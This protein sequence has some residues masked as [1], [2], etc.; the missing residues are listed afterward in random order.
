MSVT[1]ENKSQSRRN[2]AKPHFD[3]SHEAPIAQQHHTEHI[4]HGRFRDDPYAWL[5]AD[6]WREILNDPSSLPEAIAHLVKD[7]NDYCAKVVAPLAELR[8]ILVEELRARIKEDDADVP[9]TDGDYEYYG[10]FREGAEHSLYCRRPR[11]GGPETILLDGES[12]AKNKDF[13]D[14]GEVSHAPDHLQLAWSVDETGSELFSIRTRAISD[15]VDRDDVVR[16]TDGAIVWRADSQG[17]YYVHI[18]GNHRS[19]QIRRHMLGDDPKHDSIILEEADSAWFISLSESR[20]LR[21]AIVSLHGHDACE[22]WLIDLRGE[23]AKPQLVAKREEKLRYEVEPHEDR[24]YILNN[25]NGADDFCISIAPI[26]HSAR[27]HWHSMIDHR[28]GAMITSMTIYE[29]FLVWITRENSLPRITIRNIITHEEHNIAFKEEAYALALDPGLEFCTPMLRF[30]YSSLTTPEEIY[31]YNM[32]TNTRQLRKRQEIP[33]G[34]KPEDYV[35]RRLFAPSHDGEDIPITL[36]HRADFSTTNGGA[37]L[38]LYGYGAYGYALEAEF[39]ENA[40]SLVDRGFV[41]ALAHVRGGAD[42]GW[43]WYERGKLD[44]KENSFFDFISVAQFLIGA[45]YAYRGGIVAQGASAGGMLMG[46][47]MN[48]HPELFA[49]VIAGV[50]FVDVLNTMLR[51][52][53]PL[54]PPEWLEWGNPIIDEQAYARIAAYAPYENISSQNYP[55]LLSITALSDPRVTYWEPLKWVTKLRATMS[56]GGPILLHTHTDAGHAGASGRFEALADT[57]LEFAF[58]IACSTRTPNCS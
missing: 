4:T 15:G 17:F 46:V 13:F 37:P 11:G 29:N 58:A 45:G 9:D 14:I 56:G 42:K 44:A 51:D 28:P 10:R 47:V 22:C 12:L 3:L 32:E 35:T 2:S 23:D 27:I 49:G 34:H 33:C 8:K 31:D 26:T 53:L 24:L 40:L 38:L 7:E 41:Y 43:N 36:L 19:A 55:A 54:T 52:D 16:R 5:A 1:R 21:F 50:P 6:N 18:D 48:Q 39:D 20:C 57:A 30:S 25:A